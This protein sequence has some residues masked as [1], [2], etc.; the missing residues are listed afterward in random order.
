MNLEK[1]EMDE[2]ICADILFTAIFV[3]VKYLVSIHAMEG[4]KSGMQGCIWAKTTQFLPL[5]SL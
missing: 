5:Q 2:L 3:H 4:T 1:S